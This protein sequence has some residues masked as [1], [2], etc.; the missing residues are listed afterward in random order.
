MPIEKDITHDKKLRIVANPID[1]DGNAARVDGALDV[2]Q[3]IAGAGSTGG[4]GSTQP[5]AQPLEI[6]LLPDDG[7][8]GDLV[9]DVGA[10]ADLGT[11]VRR[12]SDTVTLHVSAPVPEAVG[13]GLIVGEP[14]PK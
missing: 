12:I 7:F 13:L 3:I 11:G 2:L 9:F 14:E 4:G 1:R 8:L 10:D 5:G 6:F